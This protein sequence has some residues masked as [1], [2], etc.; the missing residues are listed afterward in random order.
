MS[1]ANS[2]GKFPVAIYSDDGMILLSGLS[3]CIQGF[4]LEN[5]RH[6]WAMKG[7]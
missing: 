4:M 1:G 3:N 6:A 2:M 5:L 7:Q